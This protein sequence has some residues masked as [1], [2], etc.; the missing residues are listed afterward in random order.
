MQE[1]KTVCQMLHTIRSP[2]FVFVSIPRK[3]DPQFE[4]TVFS[5]L[6]A[7]VNRLERKP[8]IDRFIVHNFRNMLTTLTDVSS[9]P[10][11]IIIVGSLCLVLLTQ[12]LSKYRSFVLLFVAINIKIIGLFIL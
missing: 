2:E 11:L 12:Q 3:I 5:G 4:S 8:K 9:V 7:Y 6:K 10:S 1:F